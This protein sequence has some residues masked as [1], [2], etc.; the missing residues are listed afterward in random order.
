MEAKVW[1][2]LATVALP[3][4]SKT[5]PAAQRGKVRI[6]IACE[7][8]VSDEALG[9]ISMLTEKAATQGVSLL[10]VKSMAAQLN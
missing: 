5:Y 10:L 7:Y 8:S 3:N 2:Y 1:A 9:L 6:F 4:F